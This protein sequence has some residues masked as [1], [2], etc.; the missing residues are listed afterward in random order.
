MMSRSSTRN[1]FVA[2]RPLMTITCCRMCSSLDLK[3]ELFCVILC[4]LPMLPPI[5]GLPQSLQQCIHFFCIFLDYHASGLQ[6]GLVLPPDTRSDIK[7]I[8]MEDP[9]TLQSRKEC[10][11]NRPSHHQIAIN[12][13]PPSIQP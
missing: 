10:Q 11:S 3:Q 2:K 1:S 4:S 12:R 5:P 13:R 7:Q 6:H 8:S 9:F